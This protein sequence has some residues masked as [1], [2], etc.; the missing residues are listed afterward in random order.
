MLEIL[1]Y[2]RVTDAYASSV[3]RIA[4]TSPPVATWRVREMQPVARSSMNDRLGSARGIA[5]IIAQ[6][7]FA[8]DDGSQTGVG[9][10]REEGC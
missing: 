6:R 1:R 10:T 5:A 7:Q 4:M 3:I 2:R 9:V 8:D